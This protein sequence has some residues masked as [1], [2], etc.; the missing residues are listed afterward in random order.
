MNYVDRAKNIV[1]SDLPGQT[2]PG[3]VSI[4]LEICTTAQKPDIVIIKQSDKFMHLFE[5]TCLLKEPI[6]KIPHTGD[7]ES[8]D[9]C[10]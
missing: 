3:G 5:L 1:Y 9:P 4:P 8:L 6:E 2:A 10:G 7:T